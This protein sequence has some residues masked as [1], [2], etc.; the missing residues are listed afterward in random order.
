LFRP[1]R[2]SSRMARTL[3]VV[4]PLAFV[5]LAPACSPWPSA[6]VNTEGLGTS[7]IGQFLRSNFLWETGEEDDIARGMK[8]LLVR[9]G[10]PGSNARSGIESIG[11]HCENLPSA[12]CSYV[13][14]VIY[15]IDGLPQGSAHRNEQTVVTIS[16]ELSYA[17]L[18]NLIVHKELVEVPG[19]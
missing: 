7:P 6:R 19:E 13:G 1:T 2:I 18:N 4:G 8:Q 14:K 3:R 5:I 10:L 12:T 17:N 15:R 16:I 11:M 9:S